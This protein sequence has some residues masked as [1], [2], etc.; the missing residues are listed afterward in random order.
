MDMIRFAG[1][2]WRPPLLVSLAFSA[3]GTGFG[4]AFIGDVP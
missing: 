3:A 1:R 2:L 4:T